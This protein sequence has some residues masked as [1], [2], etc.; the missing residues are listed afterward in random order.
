MVVA[1]VGSSFMAA[2]TGGGVTG[3]GWIMVIWTVEIDAGTTV[4]CGRVGIGAAS[5]VAEIC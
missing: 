5:G 4:T 3:P 2:A 1:G